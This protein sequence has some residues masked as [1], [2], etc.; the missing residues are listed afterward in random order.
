MGNG[1]RAVACQRHGAGYI[2][3]GRNLAYDKL[4]IIICIMMPI[5]KTP[6][7]ALVVASVAALEAASALKPIFV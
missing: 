5:F 4:V 6:F 7:S 3:M 2:N 1:S